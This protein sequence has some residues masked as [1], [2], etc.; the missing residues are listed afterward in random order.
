MDLKIIIFESTHTHT[1]LFLDYIGKSVIK[2]KI[3][4][5]KSKLT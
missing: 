1:V 3:Y 2:S 4:Q 5:N